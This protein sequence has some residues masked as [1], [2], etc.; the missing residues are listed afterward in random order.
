MGSSPC[1]S[2]FTTIGARSAVTLDVCPPAVVAGGDRHGL[3]CPGTR[4]VHGHRWDSV[5][6]IHVTV[7]DGRAGR[8]GGPAGVDGSGAAQVLMMVLRERPI[9]CGEDM[10]LP[11]GTTV[12]V[13]GVK[14]D[15]HISRQIA[16]VGTK[17][18]DPL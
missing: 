7:L 4:A 5:P 15:G 12:V 16:T 8:P 3:S 17:F 1:R 9:R 2:V 11:D 13:I 10:V 6:V 14:I 18:D